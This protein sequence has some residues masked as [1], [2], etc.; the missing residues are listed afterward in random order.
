MSAAVWIPAAL[1]GFF[2]LLWVAAWL[3][4]L[5][6]PVGLFAEPLLAETLEQPLADPTVLLELLAMD[7]PYAVDL[8]DGPA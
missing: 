2:V 7:G 1:V 5:L 3:E 6:A 8:R 4:S